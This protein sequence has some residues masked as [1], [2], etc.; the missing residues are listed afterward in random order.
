[1][2]KVEVSTHLLTSRLEAVYKLILFFNQPNISLLLM[3][4][5]F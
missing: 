1:M 2:L 3:V 4:L 5:A